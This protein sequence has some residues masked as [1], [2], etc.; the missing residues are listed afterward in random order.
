MKKN[1]TFLGVFFLAAD[2]TQQTPLSR[3]LPSTH[4]SA[5]STEA[6]QTVSSSWICLSYAKD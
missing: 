4:Y 1:C 6:I 2:S 5:E 3:F